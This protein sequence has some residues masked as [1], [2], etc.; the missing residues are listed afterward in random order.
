MK[1]YLDLLRDVYQNG[2]HKDPARAGMPGTREVFGRM[3]RFD[4]SEG[5]P[6]L[7][8]KKMFTKGIVSEL[9][10]FLKGNT[11]IKELLD[12][13]N[14]IWVKDAYKFYCRRGG[15]LPLELWLPRVIEEKPETIRGSYTGFK[16]GECGDIYGK[17]WRRFGFTEF[18]QI[19]YI[20]DAIKNRPNERY[21]IITS[22]DPEA[23]LGQYKHSAALPSCHVFYQFNV[24][25]GKLNMSM[26]QR[27]CDMLLGVP[28][29]LA[30]CGLLLSIIANET[31]LIPGEFIWYGNS[32]HIY[33]NHITQVEEQLTREPFE[34]CTLKIRNKVR[35][36]GIYDYSVSD[37]VFENYKC[38]PAIKAP[39]SVGI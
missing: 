1:Q 13:N 35:P 32:C 2:V 10:W 37:F 18:D 26:L 23:F 16:Y 30:M 24:T 3:M 4:L 31:D 25:N 34:L 15:E 17:Q 36:N 20:I 29:D 7:T 19:D 27:S 5:F 33:D 28:F 6:L 22:W 21:H 8:T 9:L 39:L 11:N 12:N 38:H 14:K